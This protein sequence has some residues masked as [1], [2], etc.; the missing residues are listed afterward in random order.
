MAV[1][2]EARTKIPPEYDGWKSIVA[3]YTKADPRKATWQLITSFGGLFLMWI[4]MYW[5]LSV[6]YWLTLLLSI[7]AAGFVVRIF[8]I[9]HDCGHGS[10]LALRRQMT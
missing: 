5:S 1:S 4:L 3:K 8:I 9:Q 6:G 10:F 2:A 7:P